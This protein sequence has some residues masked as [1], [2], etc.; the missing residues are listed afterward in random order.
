MKKTTLLI[1]AAFCATL[2]LT[3]CE[4]EKSTNNLLGTWDLKSTTDY[5]ENGRK[6]TVEPKDGEW[7][8]YTFTEST[9]RITSNGTPSSL[10]LPYLVEDISL[11]YDVEEDDIVIRA[12]VGGF[13]VDFFELE[14]EKLTNS[15]LKIKIENP[16]ELEDGIDYS[17]S[18]YKRL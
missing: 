17:I 5:Y 7:Q 1:I 4:V 10:P 14:I 12:S 11:P 3:S 16:I 18:T 8:R 2:A 13:A 9:V 6:E 15:T